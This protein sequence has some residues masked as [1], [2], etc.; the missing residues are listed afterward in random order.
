MYTKVVLGIL[1][2]FAYVGIKPFAFEKMAQCYCNNVDFTGL[3]HRKCVNNI[4]VGDETLEETVCYASLEKDY[5]IEKGCTTPSLCYKEKQTPV[6]DRVFECCETNLCNFNLTE[7]TM[8][9]FKMYEK[10]TQSTVLTAKQIESKPSTTQVAISIAIPLS[11]LFIICSII[12]LYVHKVRKKR[13][14][15][16]IQ[17]KT[18]QR[19][20][21]EEMD[22]NE[23]SLVDITSSGSGAGLPLLVQRTIARQ[24]IL[25][26]CIGR[27]GFGDV[28]RGTWNE[29]DVAV[30]IFSTNEEASWF[31]E[32]QIY[33]TT[34]LRHENILGFIAADSK[35]TGACTQLWLVSEFHKLGSLFDFLHTNTVSLEELFIMAISIVNGLAHLHTEVIGTQGKPAMAH[36]DMKSKNIL[37]KN[38]KTCCIADLGLS[39]LHTSFNDKVDMP[40][41]SKIGTVRYQPPEILCGS[42]N[43]QNFESYRQADIYSLGL[44]FWEICRRTDIGT[45]KIHSYELPYF[46][47]VNS[48]PSFEEMN[49]VVCRQNKRPL[50]DESWHQ[51]EKLKAMVKLLSECW[52][53]DSAAR[54][55]ALRIKKTLLT[56]SKDIC[57]NIKQK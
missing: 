41:T 15:R 10:D 56:L 53:N 29:Q 48:D 19:L 36:R 30:K 24:I 31:R 26:E 35:D 1:I 38:N 12:A 57:T 9:Y 18:R 49:D 40:N 2:V 13:A 20:L 47:A 55:S 51:D 5:S 44:C 54:L 7:E 33:Q 32:Y 4:C 17:G 16:L 6:H 14:I 23:L 27:G 43:V 8:K 22:L 45:G 25:H 52:Y 3:P 28:Y 11:T 46:D 50:F 21:Q 37:V 39:V 34:M 42:F